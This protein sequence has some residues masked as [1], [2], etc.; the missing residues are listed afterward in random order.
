MVTNLSNMVN[1]MVTNE[2]QWYSNMVLKTIINLENVVILYKET[3][4]WAS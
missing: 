4:Q 3:Q 2:Q 1:Y